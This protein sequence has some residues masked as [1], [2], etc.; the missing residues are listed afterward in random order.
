MTSFRT[1][2]GGQKAAM[3]LCKA[4]LAGAILTV[5]VSPRTTGMPAAVAINFCWDL[6][7]LQNCI[8]LID[9][10][11]AMGIGDLWP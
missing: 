9:N 1:R 11:D 10:V 2:T 7:I 4:L 5:N 8:L 6:G 3:G